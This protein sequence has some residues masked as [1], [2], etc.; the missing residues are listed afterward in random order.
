MTRGWDR[1]HAG[2]RLRLAG[3]RFSDHRA[4][5]GSAGAHSVSPSNDRRRGWDR[6]HAGLRLRLAGYRL[7]DPR[8]RTGS[9]GA[10]S[11]SHSNDPRRGWDRDHRR[12]HAAAYDQPFLRI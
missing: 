5:T 3:Y 1:D 12:P 10:H 4:R 9:A 11:V 2:L 7:R 8:A 6:D